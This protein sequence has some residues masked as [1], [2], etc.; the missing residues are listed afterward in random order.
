MTGSCGAQPLPELGCL[1]T[2]GSTPVSGPGLGGG[3]LGRGGDHWKGLGGPHRGMM[4]STGNRLRHRS[5]LFLLPGGSHLLR[6]ESPK[7]L[8][9]CRKLPWGVCKVSA[10]RW[11]R[12]WGWC[13]LEQP[14]GTGLGRSV[15]LPLAT[16]CGLGRGLGTLTHWPSPHWRPGSVQHPERRASP[17]LRGREGGPS[18]SSYQAR[19]QECLARWG[20]V[21][22]LAAVCAEK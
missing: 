2:L 8:C 4:G 22:E 18:A 9:L 6:P 17:P 5:A 12:G 14:A 21:Q 15:C 1:L 7:S 10:S 13:R 3:T 20:G 19:P 11:G 16:S